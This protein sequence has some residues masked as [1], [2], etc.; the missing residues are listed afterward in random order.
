MG[1]FGLFDS[2]SDVEM[3]KYHEDEDYRFTQDYL[4]NFGTGLL[5]GNVPDYYSAIGESGSPEFESWLDLGIRDTMKSTEEALAKTG[6]ARGGQLAATTAQKI[7]DK[8]I[9]ERYNDYLRSLEGK[10]YLLGLGTDITE[11]VRTAGQRE[12][13]A[14]NKFSWNQYDAG[15]AQEQAEDDAIG[16]L[17]GTIA[18]VGLGAA[19]GGMSLGWQGALAGG[20]DVLTG[21]GTDFLGKLGKIKTPVTEYKNS[22]PSYKR[23]GYSLLS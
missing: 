10:K 19:T 15:V 21:G 6:R 20:A 17:I 18:S 11:G 9:T 12:G 14:R 4:K 13:A 23:S 1:F 5:S 2:G 8:S 22:I 7:S 3:P 16:E